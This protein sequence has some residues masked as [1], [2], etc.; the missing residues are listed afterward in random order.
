MLN[1][2]II[3]SPTSILP[4]TLYIQGVRIFSVQ[5]ERAGLKLAASVDILVCKTSCVLV[6]TMG[7]LWLQMGFCVQNQT[8]FWERKGFMNGPP[9]DLS[10]KC[11]FKTVRWEGNAWWATPGWCMWTRLTNVCYSRYPLPHLVPKR[12]SFFFGSFCFFKEIIFTLYCNCKGYI[13]TVKYL[14]QYLIYRGH[15]VNSNYCHVKTCVAS[16]FLDYEEWLMLLLR[17]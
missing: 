6:W 9:A 16:E 14:M 1:L 8:S 5:C 15:P 13:K 11:S 12:F 3:N 10:I 17:H 4:C 7:V 2:T